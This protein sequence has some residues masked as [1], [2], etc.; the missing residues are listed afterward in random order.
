MSTCRG[1]FLLW[2]FDLFSFYSMR[3][4]TIDGV[5]KFQLSHSAF[6]FDFFWFRRKRH[7]GNDCDVAVEC[8]NQSPYR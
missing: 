6:W 7:C 3:A 4:T 1:S 8:Q 2:C 5:H